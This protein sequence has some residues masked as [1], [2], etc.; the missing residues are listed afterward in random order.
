M[1]A[2]V[3]G[4]LAGELKPGLRVDSIMFLVCLCD[5]QKRPGAFIVQ[6]MHLGCTGHGRGVDQTNVCGGDDQVNACG[7]NDQVFML[8]CGT[9]HKQGGLSEG[10]APWPWCLGV[11]AALLG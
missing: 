1:Q 4:V 2:Q 8:L 3:Q 7:G 5:Q 6:R 9:E 11:Q 10:E